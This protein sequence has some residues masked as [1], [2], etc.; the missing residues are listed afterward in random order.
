MFREFKINNL[1]DYHDIYVKSDTLLLADIFENFRKKCL[2]TYEL[3]Q[4]YFSSL[5]RL[6]WQACLKMTGVELEL[7][8]DPNMLFMIEEGIRGGITQVSDD[9]K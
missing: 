1:G 7:L 9:N 6:A 8:T 3:D 4:A 5:P 2:E